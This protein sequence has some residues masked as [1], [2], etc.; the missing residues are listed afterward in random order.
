MHFTPHP[1]SAGFSLIESTIAAAISALFLSSVFTLNI[2]TMET[3]RCAKEGV[4]ASQ[5]L[6][7][8]IESLRIAN[9]QQ[10]TDANWIA[11]NLLNA[12]ALGSAPLKNLSETLSLIPYGSTSIGN[13]QLTRTPT[14]TTIVNRNPN[15]LTENAIKVI[16]TVNYTGAP[17]DHAVSRQIV[18]IL[19]KGG[20]AK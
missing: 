3:I 15:L 7:Q 9:W 18:A 12:D 2:S 16:W 11:A 5:V 19:A 1:A 10:I 6:Q 13:T 4:S 14:G 17:N 20:V 8:R